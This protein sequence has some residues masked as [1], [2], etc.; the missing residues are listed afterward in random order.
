MTSKSKLHVIGTEPRQPPEPP[1]PLN[2]PG[3]EMWDRINAAYCIDD[4]GGRQ[5]LAMAAQALDR[6]EALAAQIDEDGMLIRTA[7][8]TKD[9][10]LLK[11][12]LAARALTCRL[13]VR[14]GLNFEAVRPPGRPVSDF[15]PS[16]LDWER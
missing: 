1:R 13:L 14:L 10:P 16:V 15:G 4:E 5:I 11:H 3:R 8:G 6:A 9:H 7:R 12:E 2:K